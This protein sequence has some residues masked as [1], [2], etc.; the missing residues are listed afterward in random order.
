MSKYIKPSVVKKYVKS[1]GKRTSK[2]F[3]EAF[4]RYVEIKLQQACYEHNGGKKTLDSALAGYIF[5]NK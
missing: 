3:L 2:E 4:D 5:G 1:H